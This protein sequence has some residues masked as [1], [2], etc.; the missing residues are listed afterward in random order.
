MPTD[1]PRVE[2]FVLRFVQDMPNDGASFP[3]EPASP[4]GS[5]IESDT[6]PRAGAGWHAVAV[7]VQ[8]NE[9]KN[10]TDFA[11]A[12]AFISRYVPLGDFVLKSD[13]S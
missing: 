3:N 1:S 12:I 5:A 4:Y 2:S 13:H 7:H 8:T 6:N 9:E 10:F 11:D